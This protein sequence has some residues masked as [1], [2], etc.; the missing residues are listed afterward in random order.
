M[1]DR[2]SD[3]DL[4]IL[5][6]MVTEGRRTGYIA[7]VLNRTPHAVSRMKSKLFGVKRKRRKV[8]PVKVKPVSVKLPRVLKVKNEPTTVIETASGTLTVTGSMRVHRMR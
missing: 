5:R 1:V 4:E 7:I 6:R 2:W 3:C 8:S